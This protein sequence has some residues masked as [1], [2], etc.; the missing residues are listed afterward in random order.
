MIE[1]KTEAASLS[2]LLSQ[3]STETEM[4]YARLEMI[5]KEHASLRD[6]FFVLSNEHCVVASKL[7]DMKG[8]MEELSALKTKND[9]LR[10]TIQ[11]LEKRQIQLE[12]I[13]EKDRLAANEK[14]S[15]IEDS[16][17]T[18]KDAYKSLSAHAL[19]E[20]NRSFLDLAQT[21]FS[22]YLS[23]AQ[24]DFD[25]R[26]RAVKDILKPVADALN[27]YD[28]EIRKME[29]AREKAYGSLSQ[30]VNMLSNTQV[31]LKA[32][33]AKLARA[34]NEPNVRGRWG[35]ITLKR[36]VELA[37]MTNR[38]DFFEQPSAQT[39]TGVIRPDM[40]ILLPGKR[41]IIIDAKVPLF[42]YLKAMDAKKERERN[43]LMAAHAKQVRT[44]IGKLAQKAYW[45]QFDPTPDFVVLFIPGENFFSAALAQNP[46]LIEEGV[47]K[48]V[49]LATPTTLISLLRTIAL[50]W[51]QDTMAENTQA[52][53][54]LGNEL[55]AR[56][57]SVAKH[58]NNLGRNIE[59]CTLTYNQVVG[60]LE[61]RALV[62][63]RKLKDLGLS[64][65]QDTNIPAVPPVEEVVRPTESRSDL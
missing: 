32:E 12:T 28:N 35:E 8:P 64:L 51:R 9:Q 31:S 33:T 37:G 6:K 45:T 58:I 53:C 10:T 30:Q 54:A 44:H 26:S 42:A 39:K 46:S 56:L 63:A 41:Q 25:H 38:C 19:R 52:I 40:R 62:P 43:R 4:L 16:R 18:M 23:A 15:W 59:R 13:L 5:K 14:I 57:H 2:E 48:N 50:A 22:K 1:H 65:K 20:N 55:Y 24:T 29:R 21:A 11:S 49:I 27:R 61:R 7:D 60:S 36:V 34:L 47:Q 3:K 17:N